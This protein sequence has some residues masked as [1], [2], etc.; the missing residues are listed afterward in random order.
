MEHIESQ[1]LSTLGPTSASILYLRYVNVI[2]LVVPKVQTQHSLNDKFEANSVLNLTFEVEEKERGNSS[3]K[4]G[5]TF[6][7]Q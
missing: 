3:P 2:L 4:C 6:V 5:L 7:G 1:V